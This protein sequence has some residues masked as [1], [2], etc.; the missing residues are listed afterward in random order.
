MIKKIN[1]ERLLIRNLKN[2]RIA[3]IVQTLG[4]I[5][6]LAYDLIT[7]GVDGMTN[8]PLWLVFLVTMVVSAYLSMSISV[9][10]ENRKKP[11][12]K[13]FMISLV[14]LTL[15]SIV[16]GVLTA[17]SDGFTAMKGL[18]VGAIIFVC[19]LAPILYIYFLRKKRIDE[20]SAEK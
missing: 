9:E 18:L 19:G 14:V 16:F 8:N 15:L 10:Y 7:K 20:E 6:I 5:A 3:Y 17:L 13:G 11:V 1:D 4:I 12:K 2:I